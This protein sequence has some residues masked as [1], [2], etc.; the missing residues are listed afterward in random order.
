M[1]Q[2]ARYLFRHLV[3]ALLFIMLAITAAVWLAQS[4]RYVDVVVENGAPLHMFVWLALLT[5]P[6]FLSMTLPIALLIAVLFTYQRLTQDSELVAMRAC[7]LS[8]R[9]LALPALVLGGITML[10][11]WA[12]TLYVQ[13]AASREL[14]SLRYLIQSQFSAALLR[15]GV[16]NSVDNDFTVYVQSREDGADLKGLLIH[17]GRNPDK[18]VTIRAARG[19]LVEG[20]N[21]PQV[22]VYDGLQQ[23]FDRR[24]HRLAELSFDSY[25]V[26][27][28]SIMKTENVRVSVPRERS[29]WQLLSDVDSEVDPVFKA[30]LRAELHQRFAAPPLAL[31]FT[32]IAACCLL[33]G[34]FS[35]RGQVRRVVLAIGLAALTQGVA[36]GFGQMVGKQAWAAPLLYL[37]VLLPILLGGLLLWRAGQNGSRAV[38][39]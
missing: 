37:A 17:D 23:E 20:P 38:L 21:G 5:L 33:F 25:T 31:A 13:P 39:A 16:F 10:L 36:L 22:M 34:E 12:L 26:D 11:G 7:G 35:R 32:L 28:S 9:D 24:T 18:P 27:L 14:V 30:R 6:T 4:L 15:E 2:L 29:T 1:P 19:Q 8:P 3:L